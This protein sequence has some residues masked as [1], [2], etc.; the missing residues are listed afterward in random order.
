MALKYA[1]ELG[2][3]PEDSYELARNA[4][5]H[6]NY[7]FSNIELDAEVIFEAMKSD[8]KNTEKINL[9]LLKDIGCPFIYEENSNENLKQYIKKFINE[10]E[11]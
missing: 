3:L 8:K 5:D 7:D 9:V 4:I 6:F 1:K 10:F 2:F 11:K